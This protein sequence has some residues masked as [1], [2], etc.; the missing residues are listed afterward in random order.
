MNNLTWWTD[1]HNRYANREAVDLLWLRHRA[2]RQVPVATRVPTGGGIKRL[3][4]ERVYARLPLGMRPW[5]FFAYRTILRG[6]FL[7]GY[8]G[9]MFHTLQGLCYRQLVDAKVMQ[10]EWLM[11]RDK[12][13]LEQAARNVLG[14]D[15]NG[16]TGTCS[17]LREGS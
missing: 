17:K 15:V 7:D 12:L 1:K 5:L 2:A 4:K 11:R 8:R 13:S 10:V 14:I 16:M 9:L 3:L 6:G